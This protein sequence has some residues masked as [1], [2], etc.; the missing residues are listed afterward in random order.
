MSIRKRLILARAG[1]VVFRKP[2]KSTNVTM[3]THFAR[4]VFDL[5]LNLRAILG[6]NPILARRSHFGPSMKKCKS[7]LYCV[8]RAIVSHC[9]IYGKIRAPENGVAIPCSERHS[10]RRNILAVIW[11]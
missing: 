5:G 10:G 8:L 7:W 11:A 6:P 2:I 1:L 3:R 9:N 4:P